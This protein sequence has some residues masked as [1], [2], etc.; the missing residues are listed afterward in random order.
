MK[1]LLKASDK[2]NKCMI[3]EKY[4]PG[5]L[6]MSEGIAFSG[7]VYMHFEDTID[8]VIDNC[9]QEAVNFTLERK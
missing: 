1:Y 2:C 7:F 9:P 6:E 8:K 3:C 4:L 5:F